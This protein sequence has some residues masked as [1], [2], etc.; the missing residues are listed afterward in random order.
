MLDNVHKPVIQGVPVLFLSPEK[1][2][3]TNTRVYEVN[4]HKLLAEVLADMHYSFQKVVALVESLPE[5]VLCEQHR[6][7]WL[8]GQPL[9]KYS[10]DETSAEHYQEHLVMLMTG[11]DHY[12]AE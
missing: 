10:L 7:D 4:K 2:M 3:S 12:R 9:W 8:T 6:F 1:Q 5:E 11:V